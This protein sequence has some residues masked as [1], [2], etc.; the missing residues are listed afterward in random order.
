MKYTNQELIDMFREQTTYIKFG[1]FISALQE[2]E[3][4]NDS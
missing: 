3:R 4:E 1:E 2:K